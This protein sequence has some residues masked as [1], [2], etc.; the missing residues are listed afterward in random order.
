M[1]SKHK[2]CPESPVSSIITARQQ[3]LPGG[4]LAIRPRDTRV[5]DGESGLRRWTL[6][7]LRRSLRTET[8]LS[9]PDPAVLSE[10]GSDTCPCCLSRR[11][12]FPS[13]TLRFRWSRS[14][15]DEVACQ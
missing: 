14:C 8:N 6:A 12:L 13:G 9:E 2:L 15:T 11:I 10:G 1:P 7:L 3:I 5:V 4:V